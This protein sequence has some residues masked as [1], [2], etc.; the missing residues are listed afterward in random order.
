[1]HVRLFEIMEKK[2]EA[3]FS[4]YIKCQ[5]KLLTPKAIIT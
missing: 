3:Q 1:M 2:E 4:P 5:K